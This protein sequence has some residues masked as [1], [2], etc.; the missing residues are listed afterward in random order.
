[1]ESPTLPDAVAEPMEGHEGYV[2]PHLEDGA[3][4]VGCVCGWTRTLYPPVAPVDPQRA[5]AGHAWRVALG[6]EDEG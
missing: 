3:L 6:V 4:V 5:W 2:T 1:M